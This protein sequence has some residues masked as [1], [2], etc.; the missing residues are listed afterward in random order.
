MKMEEEKCIRFINTLILWYVLKKSLGQLLFLPFNIKEFVYSAIPSFPYDLTYNELTTNS[1][2]CEYL[3]HRIV[4]WEQ[5]IF[6]RNRQDTCLDILFGARWTCSWLYEGK[7]IILSGRKILKMPIWLM[8][9][10]GFTWLGLDSLLR[11]GITF[12]GIIISVGLWIRGRK[13]NG[14][15]SW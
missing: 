3:R 5:W 11:L 6:I 4:S 7:L 1:L 2:T 8:C 15:S 10:G 14:R 12:P 13:K 9:M